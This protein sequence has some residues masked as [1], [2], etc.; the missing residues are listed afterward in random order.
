MTADKNDQNNWIVA[1]LIKSTA[2]PPPPLTSEQGVMTVL[3]T[4]QAENKARE[5]AE[6]ASLNNPG[7]PVFLYQRVGIVLT[8]PKAKWQ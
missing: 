5:L 1:M 2:T 7:T 3:R 6:A 4:D 8:E